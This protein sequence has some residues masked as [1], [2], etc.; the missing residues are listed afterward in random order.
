M[1]PKR[2]GGQKCTRNVRKFHSY[3]DRGNLGKS[4]IQCH[5]MS[6]LEANMFLRLC[7][8][9]SKITLSVVIS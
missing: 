4:I 8:H 6:Q 5:K 2:L 1:E 3:R 9:Y 7:A